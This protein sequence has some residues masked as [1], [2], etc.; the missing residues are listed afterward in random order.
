MEGEVSPPIQLEDI[1][2][3]KL[4]NEPAIATE[5]KLL[6]EYLND[7]GYTPKKLKELP[8][9]VVKQ[10]MR[11]ATKYANL[12]MEETKTNAKENHEVALHHN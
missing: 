3:T 11:E 1:M 9:R 6:E 2:S 8:E 7:Q 5:T 12:K 10:L 4:S